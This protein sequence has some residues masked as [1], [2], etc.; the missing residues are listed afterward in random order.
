MRKKTFRFLGC[1]SIGTHV[2][3]TIVHSRLTPLYYPAH[4]VRWHPPPSLSCS[5]PTSS[6]HSTA[7]PERGNAADRPRRRAAHGRAAL[8]PGVVLNGRGWRRGDEQSIS[9]WNGGRS[10]VISSIGERERPSSENRRETIPRLRVWLW[11]SL[12]IPRGRSALDSTRLC[13]EPREWSQRARA[14]RDCVLLLR[15]HLGEGAPARHDAAGAAVAAAVA[16]ALSNRRPS[17][18]VAI[19]HLAVVRQRRRVASGWAGVG[20]GAGGDGEA[21]GR[22]SSLA[23]FCACGEDILVFVFRALRLCG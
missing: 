4:G 17:S 23:S 11:S 1:G 14:V 2:A 12:M 3:I 19:V 15:P 10:Q 13:E 5:G 6:D 18:A 7:T 21:R 8:D 16:G 22:F 20:W 9:T